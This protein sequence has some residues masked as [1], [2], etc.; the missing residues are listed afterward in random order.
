MEGIL[1]TSTPRINREK[2]LHRQT[3]LRNA[4]EA[5]PLRRRSIAQTPAPVL[6][7]SNDEH[8]RSSRR[9]LVD[10]Q[11]RLSNIPT[12][13][14][15]MNESVK[16]LGDQDMKDHI[17]LCAK[18]Y[19]ENKITAKNA[20]KLQIIDLLS[21]VAHKLGEK[22][23]LQMASTSLDI[24]AKVY[25]IRVDD[26]YSEGLK[27]A[28]SMAR[29]AVK[30]K[31]LPQD[32]DIDDGEA[33]KE[34]VRTTRKKKS[35]LLAGEKLTIAKDP[36]SLVGPLPKLESV[37]FSKRNDTSSSAVDNL[38]NNKLWMDSSGYRF[39][40]LS[41]EKAWVDGPDP[42][43]KDV[44]NPDSKK[45]PLDIEPLASVKLCVQFKDFEVDKFDPEQEEKLLA[46]EKS[47]LRQEEVVFDDNGIPIPE[48][49]G[50][51]HD[52]FTNAVN[53]DDE[54]PDDDIR[55]IHEE[56][57]PQLGGNL[58][59]IVQFRPDVPEG[60]QRSEY[61]YN[62]VVNTRSGKVIDQIWAGPSHWKLKCIKS[63]PAR[64]SGQVVEE[65]RQKRGKRKALPQMIDFD[66]ECDQLDMNAKVKIKRRPPRIT[67]PFPD[68]FCIKMMAHINELMIKPGVCPVQKKPQTQADYE[69]SAYKYENPNDSQYCPQGNDDDGGDD[70]DDMP[71]HENHND[72]EE[73]HNV[74]QQRFLGDNLVDAPETVPQSYIGYALQA[75]KMNMKKLKT[76]V[77]QTL[78][79]TTAEVINDDQARAKVK[80]MNFSNMYEHLPDR[81][82]GNTREELSCPLA[83][84][85]LLHL[86]NEQNLQLKQL[87]GYKDFHIRG[88][89]A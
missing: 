18:L 37:F 5:S 52:I 23:T 11:R 82:T 80:P 45:Y 83:F 64:F 55:S 54:A 69:V 33:E 8:E 68:T 35:N 58:E 27:L 25:S 43:V 22:E 4:V 46:R 7:R 51:V 28:R 88:P 77:W 20:W 56:I 71:M 62:A 3:L 63:A 26:L 9:S 14:S 66:A 12:G 61:S 85:A 74:A 57:A 42:L 44:G 29:I 86:A 2:N 53:S 19:N 1:S 59:H 76:A 81:L 13:G 78:T 24:S 49:D 16:L 89:T 31:E 50:S 36:T 41:K 6:E 72:I 32:G 10:M 38:S 48:L 15:P 34:N 65:K 79:G 17:Q 30:E 75:K 39:M 21:H 84:V 67:L 70:A 87:P 60:L 47:V 73:E 40:L